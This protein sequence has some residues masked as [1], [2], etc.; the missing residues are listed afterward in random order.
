MK[1]EC[2]ATHMYTK[3][4]YALVKSDAPSM[5]YEVREIENRGMALFDDMDEAKAVIEDLLQSGAEV[6]F[7]LTR[8]YYWDGIYLIRN[9]V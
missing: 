8:C 2:R 5:G 7:E 6:Y 3:D 4:K 1:L 9:S